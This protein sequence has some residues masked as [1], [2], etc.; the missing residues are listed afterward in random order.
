MGPKKKIKGVPKSKE[1]SRVNSRANSPKKDAPKAAT[2]KLKREYSTEVPI[3]FATKVNFNEDESTLVTFVIQTYALCWKNYL[4]FKR[5]TRLSMFMLMTPLF[6]GW[7][8]NL[9]TE[10]SLGL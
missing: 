5:K 2:A 6:V 3:E 9:I 10:I 8:L 1:S 7:L 4:I